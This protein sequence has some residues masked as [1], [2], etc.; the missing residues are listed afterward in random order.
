KYMIEERDDEEGGTSIIVRAPRI[1]KEAVETRIKTEEER[2]VPGTQRDTLKGVQN[3]PGVARAAFGSGQPIVWGSSRKENAVNVH[4]CAIPSLY[5]VGGLCSTINA[6]LVR[7]IDLSPGWYGSEYGRGLGGLVR[8]E[9]APLARE[10]VHG[11]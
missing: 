11:Y 9:L 2:L 8:I 3:L 1:K 5:P 7:S 6:D 4:D 10:G